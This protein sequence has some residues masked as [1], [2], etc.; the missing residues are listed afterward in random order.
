M[1]ERPLTVLFMPCCAAVATGWC[2]RPGRPGGGLDPLGFT[3]NL[4]D[5]APPANTPQ[6]AR[7]PGSSG[8]FHPRSGVPGVARV[9]GALRASLSRSAFAEPWAWHPLNRDRQL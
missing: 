1:S 8:R 3:E 4:V 5:L 2:S 9:A 6:P 7:T